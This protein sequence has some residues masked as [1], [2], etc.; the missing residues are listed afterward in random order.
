MRRRRQ[1]SGDEWN[2]IN[3]ADALRAERINPNVYRPEDGHAYVSTWVPEKCD[4]CGAGRH[5]HREV[6][7]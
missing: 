6:K 2:A 7:P 5:L 4:L 1:L 3:A